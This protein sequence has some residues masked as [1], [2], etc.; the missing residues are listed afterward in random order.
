[1]LSRLLAFSHWTAASAES[2]DSDHLNG[3]DPAMRL[4]SSSRPNSQMTIPRSWVGLRLLP[5]G[6]AECAREVPNIGVIDRVAV[7]RP[8]TWRNTPVAQEGPLDHLENRG[9][10]EDETR[11]IN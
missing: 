2:S 11:A 10:I 9:V 6:D 5:C 4:S 7:C 1:M 3:L 8:G